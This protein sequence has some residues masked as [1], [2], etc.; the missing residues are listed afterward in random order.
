M[1]AQTLLT[2]QDKE[3]NYKKIY[4]MM[5]DQ[6]VDGLLLSGDGP[7]KYVNGEYA[8][9]W[10]VFVLVPRHGDPIFFQGNEGREYV[11]TPVRKNAAD[12]WIKDFDVMTLPNMAGAIKKRNLEG[13][14]LGLNLDAYPLGLYT[15]LKKCLDAM[16]T[17]VKDISEP[18]KIIRRR[19]SG[20]YLKIIDEAADIVDTCVKELPG[21]LHTGMYEFEVKGILENIMMGRGAE[22]T[23]ILLN[24]DPVDISSPAIPAD[25][26]PRALQEG[27]LLVVEITVC[28]RG[29]WL[30]KIAIYSFGEPKPE[31]RAM[32]NAVDKAIW[33]SVK[34]VKPGVNSKDLVNAIDDY[35]EAKGF[36]SARKAFVSGPCGHLSG[37]DMDETTFSPFRDFYLEE[38]MLFVLHPAAALPGWEP[39]KPGIFGPGTMFLVTEDGVRSL[40]KTNNEIYVIR[41]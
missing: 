15:A 30:Q 12:Y 23:L 31:Y 18:F 14:R 34:M 16:N 17:E 10:G 40:N 22:N 27:D 38:G 2:Q 13:K 24:A 25:H 35:I 9:G 21:L 20:G 41:K 4:A 26:S 28:Y 5:D 3:D 1:A 39:G 32:F 6:K 36:L 11:L 19:K 33:E 8:A 7:V 29:C 37:Y